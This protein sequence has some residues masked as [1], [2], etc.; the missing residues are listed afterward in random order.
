MAQDPN[1]KSFF[2]TLEDEAFS[3]EKLIDENGDSD[4]L[5]EFLW[6]VSESRVEQV[7]EELKNKEAD[8]QDIIITN[9]SRLY[10][11]SRELIF[12]ILMEIRGSDHLFIKGVDVSQQLLDSLKN[13]LNEVESK[14]GRTARRFQDYK[15][16]VEKKAQEAQQL[17]ASTAE[18][19][20]LQSEKHKLEE[21][22]ENLRQEADEGKLKQDITNLKEEEAN[23]RRKIEQNKEDYDK[24]HA[25]VDQ[26]KWELQSIESR[27]DSKEE[28]RLLQD[29]IQKFPPDAEDEK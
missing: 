2:A 9:L 7:C 6:Y 15:K 23:L 19:K 3:I 25:T 29:L 13:I 12:Q 1:I 18:F 21:E 11:L 14:S 22:I 16:E 26:L 24:R 8:K 4:N 28:L 5:Q 10:P 17:K 27:M 20:E